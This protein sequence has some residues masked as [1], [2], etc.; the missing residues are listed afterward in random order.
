L[1]LAYAELLQRAFLKRRE[2]YLAVSAHQH[3]D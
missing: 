3:H 2:R 1:E